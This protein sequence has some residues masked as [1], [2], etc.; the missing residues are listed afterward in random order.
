LSP[1]HRHG[2]AADL[3]H[4]LPAEEKIPAQK[5]PAH[6]G[7]VRTATGP[8]PPGSSR[9]PLRRRKRRF[10][11]YAFPIRL[12]DP[13]HLAVLTRPGVVKA[14][15]HPPRHLPA[16]AAP[17]FNQVAATTRRRR[18]LTSTQPN[19]ASRRTLAGG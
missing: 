16:Q 19:S 2:Y 17:S 14:A 7:R 10:L 15:C 13:H 4:G 6:H 5:F 1:R 12:P 8:D 11:A 3:H 9:Q 18:S